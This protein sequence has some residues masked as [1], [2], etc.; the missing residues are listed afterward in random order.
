MLAAS[1]TVVGSPRRRGRADA[2]R[3]GPRCAARGPRSLTYLLTSEGWRQQHKGYSHQVPGLHQQPAHQEEPSP[4]STFRRTPTPCWSPWN[5]CWRR[6]A[7]STWSSRASS[8]PPLRRRSVGVA[9]G[10]D[11]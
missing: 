11:L 5:D 9:L 10:V 7:E 3:S 8:P 4:V 6:P 1:G 2:G